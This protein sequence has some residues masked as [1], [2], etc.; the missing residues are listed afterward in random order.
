MKTTDRYKVRAEKIHSLKDITLEKQRLQMEI[1]KKEQD[2]HNGYHNILQALSF[3]NLASTAVNEIVTSSSVLTK[4]I[5]I[6]KAFM[7][8]RKK[9]KRD[10]RNNPGDINPS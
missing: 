10:I 6:G 4:V 1:L 5:S 8:K 2:I 3:R 7:S 9:K